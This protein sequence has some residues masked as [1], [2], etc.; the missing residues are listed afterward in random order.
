M[1]SCAASAPRKVCN[2]TV[3]LEIL[4]QARKLKINPSE[5]AQ[6]GVPVAIS[7]RMTELWMHE[8]CDALESSNAYVRQ[9]GLPLAKYR[10]F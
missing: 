8:N 2:V 7:K 10:N 5:A 6:Q 3:D 1:K 4:A 9:S